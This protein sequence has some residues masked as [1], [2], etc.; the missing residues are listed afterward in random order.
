MGN[1][2]R[3]KAPRQ[4]HLHAKGPRRLRSKKREHPGYFSY[5]TT[6]SANFRRNPSRLLYPK[7]V[8]CG[9]IR[10]LQPSNSRIG[11]E[12]RKPMAFCTLSGLAECALAHLQAVVS[13]TSPF[14]LHLVCLLSPNGHHRSSQVIYTY[15]VASSDPLTH[16]SLSHLA[17]SS[18]ARVSTAT[19]AAPPR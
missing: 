6:P 2:R 4:V 11:E 12:V 10:S 8:A 18:A 5:R 1:W 16:L 7:D 9:A 13:H 3:E 17:S 15:P 19:V 14:M